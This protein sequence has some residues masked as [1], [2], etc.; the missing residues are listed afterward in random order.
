[1]RR[2]LKGLTLAIAM[3]AA[4]AIAQER[5]DG[6]IATALIASF[7]VFD[8]NGDGSADVSEILPRA[9]PVFAALDADASGS[10]E[11]GEFQAFS[12]GFATLAETTSQKT[13]Y[14]LQ[15]LAIFK[16]WD[17]NADGQ[18]NGQ[19]VTLAL[20]GEIFTAAEASVSSQQYGKAAF[21]T[22]MQAALR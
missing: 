18:L 17:A 3:L 14:Q 5:L 19:E 9:A 16:R 12:M 2:N 11:D 7:G 6:D 1:M 15:R 22:D 13:A 10:V 8:A 20:V 21:I 4:P